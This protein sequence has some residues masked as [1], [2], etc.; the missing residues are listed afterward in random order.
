MCHTDPSLDSSLTPLSQKV[1]EFALHLSFQVGLSCKP[2]WPLNFPPK[3][4][5]ERKHC[6]S[7]LCTVL[8]KI[9]EEISE[10]S[11][12]VERKR[13]ATLLAVSCFCLF[14][15]CRLLGHEIMLPTPGH[16][17]FS[18]QHS[19]KTP[20]YALHRGMPHPSPR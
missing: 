14:I 6:T 17:F 13:S 12:E 19:L 15:L 4:C 7:Y 3:V 18:R 10:G 5:R 16:I 8:I 2:P 20:Y 9:L 11:K 1:G